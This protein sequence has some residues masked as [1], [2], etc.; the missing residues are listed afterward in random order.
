MARCIRKIFLIVCLK[1]V[2]LVLS[3]IYCISHIQ[4]SILSYVGWVER[5][6]N[7]PKLENGGFRFR[8]TH[9]TIHGSAG[10]DGKSFIK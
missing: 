1:V 4:F 10:L 9:P 8:S 5:E 3:F 6:R 2:F 7:P